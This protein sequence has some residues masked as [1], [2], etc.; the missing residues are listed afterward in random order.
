MILVDNAIWNW[1]GRKW[2]HMVSDTSLEEL[3]QFA[4]SI[5]KLRVMFQGDHYDVDQTHRAIALEHG[6]L[7]VDGRDI[8]RSLRS[9]GLRQRPTDPKIDW[10]RSVQRSVADQEQMMKVLDPLKSRPGGE[11]L[12]V[13]LAR[14]TAQAPLSAGSID[15][16][17]LV[18]SRDVAVAVGAPEDQWE[19][20][21]DP[22]GADVAEA[23]AS[24]YRGITTVEL[25]SGPGTS[26]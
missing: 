11:Q 25:L 17:A 1:R 2:A 10:Q 13:E 9:S 16:L 7:A 21:P 6:A 14:V 18:G 12:V 5:G 3:H 8:V 4:T 19:T 24:S 23:Y 22:A 20:F 15:V 26:L